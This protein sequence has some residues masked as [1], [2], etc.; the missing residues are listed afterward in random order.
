VDYKTGKSR[1][2]AK[3]NLQMA[4]YSE[5]LRRDAVDDLSGEAGRNGAPLPPLP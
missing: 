3:K 1:E 5:A 4:L 2:E